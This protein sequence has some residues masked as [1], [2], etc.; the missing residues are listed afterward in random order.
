[1]TVS[2]SSI[3]GQFPCLGETSSSLQ[4]FFPYTHLA[5]VAIINLPLSLSP[6]LQIAREDTRMVVKDGCSHCA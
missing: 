3:F 6:T 2:F 4:S 5:F 1:M